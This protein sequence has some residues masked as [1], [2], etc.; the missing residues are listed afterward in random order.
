MKNIIDQAE[1]V[2][3]TTRYTDQGHYDTRLVFNW[4]YQLTH[5]KNIKDSIV[6]KELKR[7]LN[8]HLYGRI[9]DALNKLAPK[10][11]RLN[12]SQEALDELRKLL[13]SVSEV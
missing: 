11:R 8:D 4:N 9:L 5:N 2:D 13:K 12:D 10:I 1:I 7:R 6:E 3:A